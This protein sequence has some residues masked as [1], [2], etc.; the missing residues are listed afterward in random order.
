MDDFVRILHSIAILSIGVVY[1]VDVFFTVIVR[2]ALTRSSDAGMTEV[3]GRIHE[4]SSGRMP[5][6]G[7]SALVST[8]ALAVTQWLF[9]SMSI[10]SLGW[11]LTALIAQIMF[12]VLYATVSR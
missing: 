6:F 7:A 9:N 11:I 5:I 12:L 3:I 8:L 10:S 2:K 4:V 1:G